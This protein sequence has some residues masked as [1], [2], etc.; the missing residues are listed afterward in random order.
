MR[1]AVPWLILLISLAFVAAPLLRS[2]RSPGG[3]DIEALGRLPIVMDGRLQPI[4]SAGRS[5]LLRI[6]GTSSVP[7]E[8]KKIWPFWQ[9]PRAIE[10]TE[11]LLELMAKP[12][13]ADERKIFPLDDAALLR[14]LDPSA[15]GRSGVTYLSYRQLAPKAE[16]IGKR[17][18][19]ISE[20]RAS[21]RSA[22]DRRLMTLLNAIIVYQRLKNSLQ[23]NSILQ[24][25]TGGKPIDYDFP[26]LLDKYRD[27]LPAGAVAMKAREHGLPFEE[28]QLTAMQELMR[29]YESVRRVALPLV[30]PPA[31]RAESPEAWRNVG[32]ALRDSVRT[33]QIPLP[34]AYF[35]ALGTNFARGKPAEFNRSV[36]EYRLWLTENGFQREVRTASFEVTYNRSQPFIG[37][38]GLYLL[39]F[40]LGWT[41]WLTHSTMLYR[42]A[43]IALVVA[44]ALHTA[45]LL[46]RV[47]VMGR[48]P[49]TNAYSAAVFAGW[50]A[51]ALGAGIEWFR[52]NAIGFVTAAAVGALTLIAARGL[53]LSGDTFE[54]VRAG[55]NSNLWLATHVVV[56]TLGLS[57]MVLA[58]FLSATYVLLGVLTR[59]LSANVRTSLEALVYRLVWLAMLFV[60]AGTILGGFWADRVWGRF[61]GWDPKENGA[62]LVI[63][64]AAI[65][66]V[67]R[68]NRLAGEC[69][70]MALAV[71]GNVVTSF[72]WFGVN[73]LNAGLHSYGFM[74]AAFSWLMLFD[75]SQLAIAGLAFLPPRYR[76]GLRSRAA[77]SAPPYERPP[78]PNALVRG[79]LDEPVA[80]PPD[81][82][83]PIP[84]T[85]T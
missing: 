49:P 36:V 77:A 29:P 45:A 32:E 28:R 16:E 18:E 46:F 66:L 13:L 71:A 67:V 8:E 25:Q 37:A 26:A 75:V 7:L 85:T 64:W 57:A 27:V 72:S 74:D 70:Q 23:P 62:L 80:S 51:V 69:A 33:G 59:W 60:A 1:K 44:F 21:D 42:S 35:A 73:M 54:V 41:F 39:A 19:Q 5:S 82:P 20:T 38:A 43:S 22:A 81:C 47:I 83:P 55:P 3:F 2:D 11:W 10:S 53:A 34:V 61:W 63:L 14:E 65:Y 68:R 84:S 78:L 31:D 12:D 58:G 9:R 50:G 52:R 48:P 15:V 79:A 30:V 56:V 4:D 17:G 40:I 76:A 24:L 6:R